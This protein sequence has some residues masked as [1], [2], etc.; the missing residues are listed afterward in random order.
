MTR[1]RHRRLTVAPETPSRSIP[2][3]TEKWD[4]AST[5]RAMG[6]IRPVIKRWFRS[7]ISGFSTFPLGAALVVGNH[8]GGVLAMDI[9]IFAIGFYEKFGYDRPLFSL[10]H[11][12]L[13]QGPQ[14]DYL[15]RIGLLPAT[16]DNA[17]D[18]LRSG[19]VVQVFPGGSYD[20]YRSSAH[21]NTV[22]FKRRTGYVRT[23]L[24]AGVPIVPVVSIGGQETQ[25]FLTRGSGLA[26]RLGL[27]KARFDILPITVGV[28]FGA[29]VL[30]PINLPLP[31]KIT[32][33]VLEPIDITAEFGAD[34][35]PAE[36]DIHVRRVMQ[37]A[38]DDMAAHRRFPVLG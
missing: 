16:R 2:T 34:P 29:S 15:R 5:E 25:L 30:L 23:A 19:G 11:D 24:E 27:S 4:P 7:E 22:D 20:A 14:A 33:R 21:A 3:D 9:P 32:T 12:V 1:S 17:A 36:V 28:P 38:L 37:T 31:S 10:G 6:F 35:D 18:A 13:F 8:S 26:R